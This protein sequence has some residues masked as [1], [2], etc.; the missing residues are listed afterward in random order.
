RQPALSPLRTGLATPSATFTSPYVAPRGPLAFLFWL[1]R[2]GV[3]H[4]GNGRLGFVEGDCASPSRRMDSAQRSELA[5]LSRA[6]G[7]LVRA[8]RAH[9][10]A[11]RPAPRGQTQAEAQRES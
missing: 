7:R 9:R 6:Q 3:L 10:I 5:F 1:A 2:L 8:S 11:K 4:G